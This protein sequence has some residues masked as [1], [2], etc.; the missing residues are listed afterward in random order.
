M[1]QLVVRWLPLCRPRERAKPASRHARSSLLLVL[2]ARRPFGRSRGTVPRASWN[3]PFIKAAK[4]GRPYQGKRRSLPSPREPPRTGRVT[5]GGGASRRSVL[6]QLRSLLSRQGQLSL[7][8][9]VR[10]RARA[11]ESTLACEGQRSG[12]LLREREDR[13]T[14]LDVLDDVKTLRATTSTSPMQHEHVERERAASST[15]SPSLQLAASRAQS[16]GENRL[17]CIVL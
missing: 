7:H 15:G 9:L 17:H 2:S 5:V 3:R 4:R 12:W 1:L 11:G 13:R 8:V 14:L 6:L 10:E 16:Q